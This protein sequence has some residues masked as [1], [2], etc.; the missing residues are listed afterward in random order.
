MTPE[1]IWKLVTAG[2][3]LR[4]VQ[5]ITEEDIVGME[6]MMCVDTLDDLKGISGAYILG[7]YD[8]KTKKYIPDYAGQSKDIYKRLRYK[9][10]VFDQAIHTRI[11][12]W[13]T[14]SER[15]RKALEYV[16][17]SIF[18]PSKNINCGCI[19]RGAC[20]IKYRDREDQPKK[21]LK[22]SKR[23]QEMDKKIRERINT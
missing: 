4:F 1:D 2:E 16:L 10:H 20:A 8:S 13:E 17:I 12:V 7:V 5:Y 23:Y 14:P 21:I 3:C 9:H 6:C 22:F 18:Q 11:Y 15:E 19:G